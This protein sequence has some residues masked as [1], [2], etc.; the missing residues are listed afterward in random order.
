MAPGV[1]SGTPNVSRSASALSLSAVDIG[2]DPPQASRVSDGDDVLA[3][4]DETSRAPAAECARDGGSRGTGQA[5]QLILPQRHREALCAVHLAAM[6][7]RE[8]EQE[9]GQS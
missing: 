9:P 6:P 7:I 1:L 4:V 5:G 3:G 8:L 2:R